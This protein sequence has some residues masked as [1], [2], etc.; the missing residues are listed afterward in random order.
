M[1]GKIRFNI[2][3]SWLPV[4]AIGGVIALVAAGS[5]AWTTTASTAGAAHE[6]TVRHEERIRLLEAARVR[7]D[8]VE[9][10]TLEVLREIKAGIA[11]MDARID[12]RLQRLEQR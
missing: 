7:A 9:S 6:A 3:D 11:A 4:T 2:L 12:A 1:T 5:I 8:A 10:H